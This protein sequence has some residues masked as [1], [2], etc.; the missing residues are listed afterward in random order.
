[1]IPRRSVVQTNTSSR[2]FAGIAEAQD[3]NDD[4]DG[5]WR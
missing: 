1:M 3:K 5:R 4:D 2:M